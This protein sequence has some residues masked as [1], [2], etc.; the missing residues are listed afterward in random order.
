MEKGGTWTG[1]NVT[2][3]IFQSSY[4]LQANWSVTRRS[5]VIAEDIHHHMDVGNLSGEGGDLK[6]Q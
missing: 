5:V 3:S 1:H 4:I 2:E 6:F